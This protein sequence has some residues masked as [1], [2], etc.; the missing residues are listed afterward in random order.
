VVRHF[1]FADSAHLGEG[2]GGIGDGYTYGWYDSGSTGNHPVHDTTVHPGSGGSLRFDIQPQITHGGGEWTTNFSSDL[3]TRYAA[4]DEFFVQWRQRFDSNYVGPN[5]NGAYMARKQCLV[6]SGDTSYSVWNPDTETGVAQ[7]CRPIEVCMQSYEFGAV[8]DPVADLFPNAY[9]RCP[10]WGQTVNLHES[11]ASQFLLI[12]NMM[13][14]PYC[15]FNNIHINGNGTNPPTGNCFL[16][17]P[18]EWMT[19]QIGITLGPTYAGSGDNRTIPN[20]RIRI[21]GQRE[22]QPSVALIDMTITMSF[23]DPEPGFGKFWFTNYNN[24]ER[25]NQWQTWV[26][27]LI[28]ST[29]RIPDAL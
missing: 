16:Y 10:G 1:S 14:A 13:P 20:T 27:E 24:F 29:A 9:H 4:G 8:D 17:Y 25:P 5:S 12:Q 3:Q 18:N 11:S 22:G 19:F 28:I 7:S 6:S 26:S 15:G 21:W 2:P 23:P